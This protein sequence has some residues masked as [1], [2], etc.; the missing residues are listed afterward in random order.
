MIY[1]THAHYS[2]FRFDD[3]FEAWKAENGKLSYER[4]TRESLFAAMKESGIACFIEPSIEFDNIPLQVEL[5]KK[6]PD[7][8]RLAIGVHPKRA[9]CTKW[10][11]RK[12][13]ERYIRDCNA[14]AVGE[15]G[16]DYSM[17][18]KNQRRFMQKMWFK[19]Q[20]KLADELCLPLVLH[21]RKADDDAIKIL[22]KFKG[23]LHG[24]VAHCFN[25]DLETAKRYLSLGFYIGVGGMILNDG[26]WSDGLKNAVKNIPL[27]KILIETDSPYVAPEEIGGE[28]TKSK[29]K[30]VRNCS[31]ILPIIINK[32]AEIKGVTA[33]QVEKATYENAVKLFG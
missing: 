25:G 11:N 28:V 20:I 21:I 5:A 12:A 7:F 10:K 31:L 23:K 22:E 18:R 9:V 27:D 2:R 33:E 30:K 15:T 19:Y 16:L 17:P 8:I 24:G 4:F 6:Y 13:L 29:R 1:E 26:E 32:I 14:V 3:G